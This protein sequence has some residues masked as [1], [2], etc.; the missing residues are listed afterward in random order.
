[1]ALKRAMPKIIVRIGAIAVGEERTDGMD[2]C[3]FTCAQILSKLIVQ[4]FSIEKGAALD[5]G[6][7]EGLSYLRAGKGRQALSFYGARID[8]DWFG[9]CSETYIFSALR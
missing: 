6:A 2:R 7:T 8:K 9:A 4:E 3:D 1:M 5:V